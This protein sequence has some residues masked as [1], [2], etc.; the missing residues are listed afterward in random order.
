VHQVIHKKEMGS[1][2]GTIT[3]IWNV[4][5]SILLALSAVIFHS[6]EKNGTLFLKA[7]H[8]AVDL[9]IAFTLLVV[10]VAT[11]VFTK[12]NKTHRS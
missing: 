6:I 4:V 5:G 3:T 12:R 11:Y 10:I 2:I 8:G 1:A 9:N 7:F